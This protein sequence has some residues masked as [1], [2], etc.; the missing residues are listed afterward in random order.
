MGPL[1]DEDAALNV[2][3]AEMHRK[4]HV[5]VD[6]ALRAAIDQYHAVYIR[7]PPNTGIDAKYAREDAW[8]AF[9]RTYV[10]VVAG[11][12]QTVGTTS[13]AYAAQ[14]LGS[15][16]LPDV[17]IPTVTYDTE[18]SKSPLLRYASVYG[19][20]VEEV[21]H[22][23]AAA[24]A[25]DIAY[26]Y[27]SQLA[28]GDLQTAARDGIVG[29]SESSGSAIL[30]YKKQPTAGAC[31]WCVLVSDRIY[32]TRV[33]FH[34]GCRCGVSVIP[35]RYLSGPQ[36]IRSVLT[37]NGVGWRSK[38][39]L[40]K[41]FREA[42]NKQEALGAIQ[43]A[44]ERAKFQKTLDLKRAAKRAAKGVSADDLTRV[45]TDNAFWD[46]V[47][48]HEDKPDVAVLK[49]MYKRARYDDLPEVL[50]NEAFD[51][52]K[53]ENPDAWVM[54]R[55]VFSRSFDQSSEMTKQFR[56]GDY[57]AGRGIYGNGTYGQV[58]RVPP[59]LTKSGQLDSDWDEDAWFT[60]SGYAGNK[61]GAVMEIAL[62]PGAKILDWDDQ[63]IQK[64]FREWSRARFEAL[65]KSG[66]LRDIGGNDLNDATDISVYA[67]EKG[68]DAIYAPE[69]RYLVILNRGATVVRSSIS[70]G[71]RISAPAWTN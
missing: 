17:T 64:D 22:E 36:Q 8:E 15:E 26:G 4:V 39:R 27:A 51:A 37:R 56:E 49:A 63:I 6:G 23:A 50:D 18:W 5:G 65:E 61:D 71:D 20:R 31:P 43:S 57:F 34:S 58:N 55:G 40:V 32:W 38:D 25:R 9:T 67:I 11:A 2:A 48:S 21:G 62:R 42:T 3:H 33:P 19:E 14:V 60:A 47:S 28:S 45:H 53:A 12:Q 66:R 70:P 54:Y 68:Y 46:D 44:I 30:G 59:T 16:E 69:S 10:D 1:S 52:W 29:A 41:Q 35:A 24:E 7:N 13:A